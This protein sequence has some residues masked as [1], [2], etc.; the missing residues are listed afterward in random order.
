MLIGII[1]ITPNFQ[2][3]S[4]YFALISTDNDLDFARNF[5]NFRLKFSFTE[6]RDKCSS[7]W[8]VRHKSFFI[9]IGVLV[10]FSI[11]PP[12]GVYTSHSALAQKSNV[13]F[14][15][16]HSSQIIFVTQKT[17]QSQFLSKIFNFFKPP[18]FSKVKLIETEWCKSQKNRWIKQFWQEYQRCFESFCFK[19]IELL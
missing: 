19:I 13:G 12:G 7:S 16:S 11:H 17:L 15:A 8:L 10:H 18:N 4:S 9:F 1:S 2:P 5:L 3:N 14:I 6:S